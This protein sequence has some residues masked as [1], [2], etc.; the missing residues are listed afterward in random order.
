MNSRQRRTRQRIVQKALISAPKSVKFWDYS[1]NPPVLLGEHQLE[2]AVIVHKGEVL[3]RVSFGMST[4]N[5]DC[6]PI[7]G[8]K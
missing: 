6:Y 7:M 1:K 2:T 3:T 4:G 8:T 5:Y